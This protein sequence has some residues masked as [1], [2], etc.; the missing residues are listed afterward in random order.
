MSGM[1]SAK[2]CVRTQL[3]LLANTGAVGMSCMLTAA[4]AN[5]HAPMAGVGGHAPWTPNRACTMSPSFTVRI[6]W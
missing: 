5:I 2:Y 1:V 3:C 6:P 4:T